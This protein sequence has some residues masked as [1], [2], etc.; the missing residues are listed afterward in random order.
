MCC[1]LHVIVLLHPASEHVLDNP[2]KPRIGGAKGITIVVAAVFDAFFQMRNIFKK[3]WSNSCTHASFAD[4]DC[5]WQTW[6]KPQD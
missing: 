1:V 6:T 4:T 5:W 3:L 2:D